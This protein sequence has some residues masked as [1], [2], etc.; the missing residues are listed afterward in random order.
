MRCWPRGHYLWCCCDPR[1]F[2][3]E[4]T[5]LFWVFG[6]AALVFG[7]QMITMGF[8]AEMVM[9]TY[10]ESQGKRPYRLKYQQKGRHISI[11]RVQREVGS[12]LGDKN[13]C[14]HIRTISVYESASVA[15]GS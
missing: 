5:G 8:L 7:I 6:T 3:W 9:R 1:D 4:G 15:C 12:A 10:Y 14:Q 2:A 11:N 13:L